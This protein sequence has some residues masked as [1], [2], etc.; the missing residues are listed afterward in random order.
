MDRGFYFIFA[1]AVV[2]GFAIFVN[3]IGVT[4]IDAGVYTLGK[5]LVAAVLLFSLVFG[6]GKFSELKKLKKKEWIRL[7]TIGFFGGSVPFLLF[8]TGL[9]MTS[10][11]RGAFIHKSMFIYIAI[12]AAFFLREK[13][14]KK[15]LIP[16]CLLL[17]GNALFLNLPMGLG[18]GDALILLATLFWAV[19]ITISKHTLRSISPAI[20]GFGRMFFGAIFLLVYLVITGGLSNSAPLIENWP[21]LLLTGSILFLYVATFYTGLKTVKAHVAASILLLGSPITTLLSA[22]FLE[23]TLSLS[24]IMGTLLIISGVVSMVY[25]SNKIPSVRVV[26]HERT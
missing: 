19:E 8:F 12:L 21:W 6:I 9:Q 22:I 3:K 24:H 2:S 20:V 23:G 11:A 10:A 4:G 18:T 13:L 7:A 17:A 14:G 16:A 5:N 25:V 26:H 15:I 1:T